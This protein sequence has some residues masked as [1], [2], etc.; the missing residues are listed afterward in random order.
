MYTSKIITRVQYYYIRQHINVQRTR[1]SQMAAGRDGVFLHS[2]AATVFTISVALHPLLTSP[3][4]ARLRALDRRVLPCTEPAPG[5]LSKIRF[6][7][8]TVFH[9]LQQDS[10]IIV[11]IM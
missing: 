2:C 1:F 5:R 9:D 7:A 4:L 11:P 3:D 8:R 10:L 6:R